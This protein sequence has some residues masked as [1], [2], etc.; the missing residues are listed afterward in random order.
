MWQGHITLR[1]E[2]RESFLPSGREYRN[3]WRSPHNRRLLESLHYRNQKKKDPSPTDLKKHMNT[4]AVIRKL[5]ERFWFFFGL[6]NSNPLIDDP[7]KSEI[8]SGTEQHASRE[9]LL[10]E[11]T[12]NLVSLARAATGERERNFTARR[13]LSYVMPRVQETDVKPA[14]I[15]KRFQRPWSF[16]K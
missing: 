14:R 4:A 10:F 16:F 6:G 15:I 11:D 7:G 3:A 13:Q 8:I 9:R 5:F 2:L 12:A 1:H